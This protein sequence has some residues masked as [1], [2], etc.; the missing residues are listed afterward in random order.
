MKEATVDNNKNNN[1][2]HHGQKK[3]SKSMPA[4]CINLDPATLDVPYSPSIDIRDTVDYKEVM[5]QHKLG[6]NGAIMTSLN[7]YATKFDQVIRILEE[8]ADQKELS[9]FLLVDTPGQIEAFTWSASGAILSES[10]ASTFPTVMVFVVDTVRCASSP[11]TFMSNMLYACSMY[12]R[13]RLPL[14]ICFNKTDVCSHEFCMEWMEDF[15]AF[16]EA[17]DNARSEGD[18]SGGGGGSE[19]GFY[20]S[21]TRSLSLVL[22]EF[23]TEFRR[24]ACGV[25]AVTG[26][27][28]DTFWAKIKQAASVDFDEYI[29]DLKHRIE[30]QDAKKQAMARVQARRLKRDVARDN[31]NANAS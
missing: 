1:N 14:V 8:R 12:Y 2:I 15:E 27:G 23:Y 3:S 17:L 22:D 28:I 18:G 5:R 30:E 20:D 21:L 10:L 29:E 24:N 19:S 9:E 13:T 26:D 4:Y 7:L 6:P 16:Q 25:S 11:N 31:N